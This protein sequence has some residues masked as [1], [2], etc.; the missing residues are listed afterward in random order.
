MRAQI[1]E[2]PDVIP[3]ELYVRELDFAEEQA[4]FAGLQDAEAADTI[5]PDARSAAMGA[6]GACDTALQICQSCSGYT[7]PRSSLE[8][9]RR[10]SLT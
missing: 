7:L 6:S 9:M 5:P 10:L 8:L 4:A 3:E 1:E 2:L